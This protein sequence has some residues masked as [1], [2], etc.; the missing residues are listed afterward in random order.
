LGYRV[1]GVE[2]RTASQKENHGAPL[3]GGRDVRQLTYFRQVLVLAVLATSGFITPPRVLAATGT[4][5]QLLTWASPSRQVETLLYQAKRWQGWGWKHSHGLLQ[6]DGKQ[7]D[8]DTAPFRVPTGQS[9]AVQAR[10]QADGYQH[11]LNDLSV[12]VGGFGLMVSGGY[13]QYSHW[14]FGAEQG[15]LGGYVRTSPCVRPCYD[16]ACT[17]PGIDVPC[18]SSSAGMLWGAFEFAGAPFTPGRRWHTYRIEVSGNTYRTLIDHRVVTQGIQIFGYHRNVD[19]GVWTGYY[20]LRVRDFRVYALPSAKAFSGLD[21]SARAHDALT[22][23]DVGK[24]VVNPTFLSN[25]QYAALRGIP[26]RTVEGDGRVIGYGG[27]WGMPAVVTPERPYHAKGVFTIGDLVTTY[28]AVQG[29]QRAYQR[30]SLADRGAKEVRNDFSSLGATGIGDSADAF[31]FST[32]TATGKPL[33]VGVINFILGTAIVHLKVE[34]Y[35]DLVVQDGLTKVLID[36]AQLLD[37]RLHVATY[38]AVQ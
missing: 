33:R 2:Q 26:L 18:S 19:I 17:V 13:V 12:L 36:I 35:S 10:I 21:V 8:I 30:D 27:T 14:Y 34:A 3:P 7:A 31:M 25:E 37:S 20:K 32:S 1:L 24:P 22:W 6:A 9:F 16:P 38:K 11:R 4:G 5:P 23:G 28:S 15:I 29:A